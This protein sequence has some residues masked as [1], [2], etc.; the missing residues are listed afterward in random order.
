MAEKPRAREANHECCIVATTEGE[1]TP[2]A[3][4][5]E[6]SGHVASTPRTPKGGP[7]PKSREVLGPAFFAP[8]R[9]LNAQPPIDQGEGQCAGWNRAQTP[10]QA[11]SLCRD[12]FD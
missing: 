11:P 9:F 8:R 10:S 5:L 2:R 12:P 1:L 4:C 6:A 3:F 7:F